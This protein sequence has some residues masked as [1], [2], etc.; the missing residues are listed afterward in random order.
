MKKRK[1]KDVVDEKS[2]KKVAFVITSDGWGGLEM[3]VLKLVKLFSDSQWDI[4]LI[5]TK[6][7]SI[8]QKGKD[9]FKGYKI[10]KRA[11]KYFDLKNAF[12]ISKYLKDY[13]IR[14][15][16]IFNNR[17]IDMT[18]IAKKIF[19]RKL[20]IIYQQHMQIGIGK[21]DFMHTFRYSSINFWLSPLNILR[22]E[23]LTKT[24]V[25]KDKL[26]V[27]PLGINFQKFNAPKYSKQEAL[28]QLNIQNN[29][30]LVGI[31][32]RI[33][34]KKGQD[35]LLKALI[36]L[37]QKKIDIEVLIF[38]SPTINDTNSCIYHD[39]LQKLVD[40][41]GLKNLVHF[42]PYHSDVHLFYDSIDCFIMASEK[43]T[44]GMVTLEAMTKKLPIIATKHGGTS[45][46]LEYGKF[47]ILYDY[48]DIEALSQKI[49]W[50]FKHPEASKLMSQ[51]AKEEVYI[52]Y[53]QEKEKEAIE[54]L[55]L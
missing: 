54:A 18:A 35:Q 21:R 6:K 9:Y 4:F 41:N 53:R 7:S 47:G 36:C 16:M 49:E 31:I 43:E 55:I 11:K 51:K 13:R 2:Q 40:E 19:Y 33:T 15:A 24:K 30:P 38:G 39:K 34:E 10:L 1:N 46:I 5:S 25:P 8:Y 48:N 28:N 44:Y 32:G 42:R 17:D 50:V 23:V 22:Q 52:K 26:K 45:E 12:I 14:T 27:I 20:K 29:Y 3:N 37:C